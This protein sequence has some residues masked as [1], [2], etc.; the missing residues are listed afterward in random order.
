M[1]REGGPINAVDFA[2]RLHDIDYA[3]GVAPT[4]ADR[5]LLDNVAKT[6]SSLY[7][8]M[9]L[10]FKAKTVFEKLYGQA[11]TSFLYVSDSQD[12]TY[13]IH[14][15]LNWQNVDDETTGWILAHGGSI[16]EYQSN[17]YLQEV[18]RGKKYEDIWTS[19]IIKEWTQKCEATKLNN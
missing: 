16:T 15:R 2:C 19:I 1:D 7:Y 8:P 14:E 9:Y 18:A 17:W 13:T 4:I 5:L 6:G 11:Y 3:T 12:G 10:S